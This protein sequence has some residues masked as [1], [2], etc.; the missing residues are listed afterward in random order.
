MCRTAKP[1]IEKGRPPQKA[2]AFFDKGG[3]KP[4]Q[5]KRIG[6]RI[7]DAYI[8]VMLLV[9][10]FY[11]EGDYTTLTAGKYRLFLILCGGY[12]LSMAFFTLCDRGWRSR[13]TAAEL[14]AVAYLLLTIL[15][16][17]ASPYT[18]V[19]LG[20][21]RYEGVLTVALYVLSFLFLSQYG[22]AKMWQLWLLGGSIS[23][24]SLICL[25]QISGRDPLW[26]YPGE[27]GF[28]DAGIAYNG[29]FLGT[30]GNA[31]LSG[32]LLSLSIPMLFGA[33]V[34]CR[35]GRKWLLLLPIALGLIVIEKMDVSAA[36]IGVGGSV[37]LSLPVLLA[38]K[39]RKMMCMVAAGV[40]LL[41]V[42]VLWM[43]PFGG[44]SG[45][46]HA[47]LHGTLSDHFGSG[48]IGIWRQLWQFVPDY[49]LL[50]SGPDT[51]AFLGLS[52]FVGENVA[53]ESVVRTIDVAHNEYLQILICQGVLALAA[54][55]GMLL[56]LCRRWL[57]SHSIAATILGC[58]GLGYCMQAFFSFS[59][60]IMAPLF[61]LALGLL[62]AQ[63][64]RAL[65]EKTDV[66]VE[67][68]CPSKTENS[69][70]QAKTCRMSVSDGERKR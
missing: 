39:Q 7:T 22:K 2:A 34:V 24:Y 16:A 33:L 67:E 40:M 56:T 20:N 21:G 19:W 10:P 64:R 63:G 4:V 25:L 8:V 66:E 58:G 55:L 46:L 47:I 32:A 5:K 35:D 43:Y 23:M 59:M 51:V 44:T 12:V 27:L 60:C 48:R 54:Y 14:C 45:E 11:I 61:W 17:L 53:G 6:E 49:W 13:P 18:G 9:F 30:M 68:C 65:M 41:S 38:G 57:K 50:G 36:V 69:P 42:A 26:L 3:E 29:A 31:G 37:L 62:S 28:A 15:S 1:D 52:P 70:L